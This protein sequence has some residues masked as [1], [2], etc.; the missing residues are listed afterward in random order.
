MQKVKEKL[1][2]KIL[3]LAAVLSIFITFAIVFVLVKDALSFFSEVS[4]I[5]FITGKKWSPLLKPRSFGV[6]PL[7]NGTLL[8]VI[9]S[10]FIA[11]PLGTGAAVYLS[12]YASER[13]RRALKPMLEILA[14]IPTVVYGYFALT[15]ITP[16]IIKRIY[17]EADIFN[18][19]S[20]GIAVGIMVLPMV[21]SLSE[22]AMR[23]VPSGIKQGAYALGATKFQTITRVLIPASLSG[24]LASYILAISRVIGETMTVTI[25]AGMT[26]RITLNPFESIQTMTAYIVQVSLG[27]TPFG[28]IEYKTIFAVGLV[29]FVMTLSMNLISQYLKEKF[30]EAYR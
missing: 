26:P 2:E 19:M 11:I 20:A 23:A 3:F 8:I 16:E 21:A 14:G 29:L 25:A 12:E 22:D 5:E 7:I 4:F 30:R 28:T 6:L 24:I 9:I 13:V 1:I 18:A 27:D 10:A 15:F 17:S